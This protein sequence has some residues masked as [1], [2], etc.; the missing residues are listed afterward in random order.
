MN[1][2]K[3]NSGSTIE[4]LKNMV[5]GIRKEVGDFKIAEA[6]SK[7]SNGKVYVYF[8]GSFYKL[9]VKVDSGIYFCVDHKCCY[10]INDNLVENDPHFYEWS[11][12]RRMF[13]GK[14]LVIEDYFSPFHKD[15]K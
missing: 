6:V 7:S 2:A 3:Y 4:I 1:S 5:E 14:S 13:P 9:F 12:Y 11:Q 10:D 8:D 15:E